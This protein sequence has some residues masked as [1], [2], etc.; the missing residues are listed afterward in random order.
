MTR[1]KDIVGVDA[2]EF[3]TVRSQNGSHGRRRTFETRLDGK[4]VLLLGVAQ[5]IFRVRGPRFTER[6]NWSYETF[7]SV[8]PVGAIWSEQLS[9][10]WWKRWRLFSR[11]WKLVL[12]RCTLK[13]MHFLPHEAIQS[14]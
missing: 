9:L 7:P 5:E 10:P 12:A 11:S 6:G 13:W 14:M 4:L 1:G 8:I 2:L 3:E